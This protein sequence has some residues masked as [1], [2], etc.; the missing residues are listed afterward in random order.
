MI[1]IIFK[2]FTTDGFTVTVDRIDHAIRA[3]VATISGDNLSYYHIIIILLVDPTSY[4]SYAIPL[5]MK[6]VIGK[7]HTENA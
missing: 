3:A 2:M 4:A 5:V 6:L 1:V 7:A